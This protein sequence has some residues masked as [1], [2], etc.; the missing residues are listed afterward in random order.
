MT[1][2][3]DESLRVAIIGSSRFG[4][5]EPFAG[6]LEAH[7]LW[8]ARALQ[9]LGHR[10]TLFAGH[11]GAARPS[12]VETIPIVEGAPDLVAGSRIDLDTTPETARAT[13]DGYA[14]VLDAV[15]DPHRFDVVHNNSLHPLPPAVDVDLRVPMVHVLHCPPFPELER[16]HMLRRAAVGTTRRGSVIA[17]SGSL[18]SQ[19]AGLFPSVV[20]NG[21][22]IDRWTPG[23]SCEVVERCVWAGRIVEEKAPHL[24]IDAARRVGMPIVLAG[25]AHRRQYFD[26]EIAPRLGPGVEWVGHLGQPELR[27]LYA[28]SRVGL[29]TPVWE[30]PFGL[31]IAEMLACGTPVAAFGRG[32]VSSL[33]SSDIGVVARTNTVRGLAAAIGTAMHLDRARCRK[34]AVD[35]L[36]DSSMVRTYIDHYRTAISAHQ[37]HERRQEREQRIRHPV[38]LA[39]AS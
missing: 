9:R 39:S 36:S 23:P 5:A 33:L 24:A 26:A 28:T 8:T 25:P 7:T 32:A 37:G 20:T 27:T 31:V 6:G 2:D 17:V 16:A 19:W 4:A 35:R 15:D 1:P 12:D 10:V 30:E 38:G 29:V 22:P 21:V 14:R 11:G 13:T 18:A 3:S 34:Y